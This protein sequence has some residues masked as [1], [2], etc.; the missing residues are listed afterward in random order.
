MFWV[1]DNLVALDSQFTNLM[2]LSI[3]SQYPYVWNFEILIS[4]TRK[5]QRH[6]CW[7]F[8]T[9]FSLKLDYLF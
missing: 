1:D 6:N 7:Y 4:Y 2:V 9:P 3:A 5:S 8:Q